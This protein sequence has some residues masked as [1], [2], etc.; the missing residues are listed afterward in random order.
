MPRNEVL[1][2]VHERLTSDVA[3]PGRLKR[4][5]YLWY[6]PDFTLQP[7]CK[8]QPNLELLESIT[9]AWLSLK[10]AFKYIIDTNRCQ[11]IYLSRVRPMKGASFLRVKKTLMKQ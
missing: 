11:T 1:Q 2:A 7:I 9:L 4:L 8:N 6:G 10:A 5:V 3:T